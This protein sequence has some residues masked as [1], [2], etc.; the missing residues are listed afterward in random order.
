MVNGWEE[1]EDDKV[2][3]T[4]DGSSNTISLVSIGRVEIADGGN[5]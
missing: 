2:D 3:F 1:Q 5:N 4:Y